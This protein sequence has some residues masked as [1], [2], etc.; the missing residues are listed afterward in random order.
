MNIMNRF[1]LQTLYKNKLRTLVTIIGIILSTA[2]FTG[3][4][5]IVTSLQQYLINLEI[6]DNGRWEGRINTVSTDEAKAI[7]KDKSIQSGISLDNI[8]YSILNGGANESK[9]YVC[10]ES[11][12]ANTQKLISIK[13]T[14]GRM[15]ANDGELVIS[16][17]IQ[18]DGN[19]T[20]NV[21]DIITLNFPMNSAPGWIRPA[22][23]QRR[24]STIKK[25]RSLKR[26]KTRSKNNIRS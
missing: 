3:V 8:G 25:K 18:T 10:V 4:T 9:P 23:A 26:S 16:S 7:L 17:H 20:Y 15:P 21:G 24:R 19:V 11:I 2:M 5:S 1:T 13:L 6:N 12:P 22:T 14:E